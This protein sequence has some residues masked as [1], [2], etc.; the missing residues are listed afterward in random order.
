MGT[1]SI[2]M[3]VDVEADRPTV[4][5]ALVAAEGLSSWW[6]DSVAG[7]PSQD[8]GDLHVSFPDLP[9]PFHFRVHLGSEKVS[10]ETLEFPPW[11][12]GTT[13]NW[14]L[15]AAP[16]GPGT[17]VHFSHDGF[18]PDAEIVPVITPAWAG[19]IERL[20]HYAETG[21]ADPFARNEAAG[22]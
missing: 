20:K 17:R 2:R 15:E 10:W 13:I 8:G 3:Q 16:D 22:R 6:S 21:E 12:A 14:A 4:H 19:I 9:Q 1:Y 5:Q 7:E 18:E 11:W